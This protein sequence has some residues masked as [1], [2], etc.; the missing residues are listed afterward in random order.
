MSASTALSGGRLDEAAALLDRLRDVEP[1]AEGTLALHLE[2]LVRSGRLD[3]A[4][5]TADDL[6]VAFPASGRIRHWAGRAAAR[7]HRW[8]SAALHFEE[9]LRL[10]PGWT[11][12]LWLGKS[13][14]QTGCFDRAEPLLVRVVEQRPSMCMELAWL[15][16]RMGDLP[17][18]IRHAEDRL[19]L[20]PGDGFATERLLRLKAAAA[21]PDLVVQEVEGLERLGERVPEAILPRSLEALLQL[22]RTEAAAALVR[23]RILSPDVAPATV[24]SAAWVAYRAQEWAPAWLLF[25]RVMATDLSRRGFLQALERTARMAGRIE[26]LVARYERLAP[27]NHNLYGRARRLR[28][29]RG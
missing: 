3:D 21:M 8:G 22:G 6:V 4:A 12:E 28:R 15:Y 9:A 19:R 18:A 24:R 11:N 26:D 16:E 17:R 25:E 20:A 14:T 23:D 2:L 27:D 7:L 29:G 10:E 13:L 5:H 1:L